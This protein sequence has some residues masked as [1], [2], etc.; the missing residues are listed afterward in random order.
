MF[1][2]GF[3]LQDGLYLF[4]MLD[5]EDDWHYRNAFIIGDIYM[6]FF[7]RSL[8]STTGPQLT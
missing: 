5:T 8:A 3:I 1:N 2:F 6:R 4:R 7:F